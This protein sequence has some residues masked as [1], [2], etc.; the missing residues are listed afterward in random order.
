[1]SLW[2]AVHG[3]QNEDLTADVLNRPIY[4]LV[5]RTNYLYG[6]INDMA[7][8][9]PFESARFVDVT[10]ATADAL[11]PIVGDFVYLDA[12]TKT[13][14]KASASVAQDDVFSAANSAYAVGILVS[15]AS[16]TGTVVAYGK[17]AL[18]TA[19][20]GWLLANL[21]ETGETF[22][23]GPYYL[24]SVEP[25]RMTA[26]PSGPAIYLGY[27][28][29][30][31]DNLGYGGYALLAPQ[32]K[33][34]KEAHQHRAYPLYAQPAGTQAVTGTTPIDTHAIH[35]F[36]VTDPSDLTAWLPYLVVS[37]NWTGPDATTY[38][39]WISKSSD[40]NE[41]LAGSV[42]PTDWSDLYVHWSS[43]DYA[44][45][46][47][48]VKVS[49]FDVKVPIGAKGLI[50]SLEKPAAA[51]WDVPYASGTGDAEDKR[52]WV[53]VAPQQTRGWLARNWY[54]YF[55]VHAA[56]DNGFSFVLRGG[57]H[58]SADNREWDFLSI[59]SGPIYTISY[60]GVANP[61]DNTYLTLGDKVYE[62]TVDGVLTAPT[63][64]PVV[65]S[66]TVPEVMRNLVDA[67]NDQQSGVGVVAII[68]GTTAPGVVV[69]VIPATVVVGA[70]TFPDAH[71]LWAIIPAGGGDL[72]GAGADLIVYDDTFTSLISTPCYWQA[73][74]YWTLKTLT[75][76]LSILPVP[77]GT[78]GS[79]AGS[80][81]VASG[82]YFDVEILDEAPGANF[83][84]S[85]GMHAELSAHYP[86]IPAHTADL[87]LNGVALAAYDNFPDT[88]DYR[89]GRA[90]VCWYSDLYGMVPWPRDWVDY[91]T[92]VDPA[93]VQNLILHFVRMSIG[94]TGTITSLRPAPNAPVRIT[95]C[96]TN[97][98]AT[99][100]D[101]TIN[102]DLNLSSQNA[103]MPGYQVF[104]SVLGQ[105]LQ[106]GPVVEK[107]MCP[108]GS[109][110]ITQNVGA[111]AGQGI[112]SLSA[113]VL[114]FGGDF[115]EVAL[116]NAKQELIGMFPYIKLLGWQT[117]GASNVPSGFVAK[118]RVPHTL[119]AGTGFKV[120]VYMT[121]FGEDSI[122][123]APGATIQYAGID[124][125]YSILPDFTS[126]VYNSSV[127]EPAW[128]SLDRQLQMG[129]MTVV[130]P[131]HAA[132]PLGDPT[133]PGDANGMVYSAYDPMLIH[134][135]S[136]ETPDLNLSRKIAKILGGEL[137]VK[138]NILNWPLAT[139]PVVMPGALVGI[140][141]QR[142]DLV[143]GGAE[144]TG[145]LGFINIRWRLVP[146]V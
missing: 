116:E 123:Y 5:E 146:Y 7:A 43:S 18:A 60:D 140:R 34:L 86:P 96:G 35:G 8:L 102:V 69:I 145:N 114:N 87:I 20:S 137:P 129:L 37:G 13:F 58:S 127:A 55:T 110:A 26:S 120:V 78:D 44:E 54:Q 25:G 121:V 118:F 41:V 104:K 66:G 63:N 82:D 77:Y 106:K 92:P 1:M 130:E 59:R 142:S 119:S 53:V 73:A 101:L 11:T 12:D 16:N 135:N 14:K 48:A 84:Y 71:F 62:F 97:E 19:G 126:I 88:P 56:V 39:I 6:R 143:A 30:D 47:G 99:M 9:S 79:A 68:E 2:V 105:S 138:A 33:D 112:V 72:A 64:I 38:T 95:R 141:V 98:V 81:T 108:D 85:T 94:D 74:K 36:T 75:N 29:Q 10:I 115:E 49:S 107:I 50:V 89:A 113:G 46:S 80:G 27:F 22:R 131:I 103:S 40:P 24:S 100:G 139:E 91:T 57:P 23:D 32:Y 4:E 42:E 109:I 125:S 67:I 28:T 3:F 134:N 133:A 117:G 90:S 111:P 122:P 31:P 132:I 61:V 52:S 76:G 45:A 70:M 83:M 51:T 65:I 144:Y 128:N 93:Y 17:V 124:F 21:V 15:L 136:A